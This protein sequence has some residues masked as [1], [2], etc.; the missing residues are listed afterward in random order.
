MI[1]KI[2]SN[3][4]ELYIELANEFYH[5]DGVLHAVD[6]RVITDTYDEL[7]KSDL[8]LECFIVELEN[9]PVGYALLS[10]MFSPEVGGKCIWIEEIYI[11]E[12]YRG[13]GLGKEFFKFL[14]DKYDE[15]TYRFRLEAVHE[16][17]KA[18]KLYE[19]QG[20]KVLDYVQMV[21]DK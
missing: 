2:T 13:N 20:F 7:I 19:K 8:Y 15:S 21:I 5:S 14:F 1:R 17:E 4:R 10:K 11:R 3:D 16:N 12:Q 6:Q 9:K 18:M